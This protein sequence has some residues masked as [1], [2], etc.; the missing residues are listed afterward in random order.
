M[1]KFLFWLGVYADFSGR[2]YRYDGVALGQLQNYIQFPVVRKPLA[3]LL[4]ITHFLIDPGS[5]QIIRMDDTN[6]G[7]SAICRLTGQVCPA[8]FSH[9]YGKCYMKNPEKSCDLLTFNSGRNY[10]HAQVSDDSIKILTALRM[11]SNLLLQT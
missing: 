2:P 8:G 4:N 5:S 11:H 9:Y 10:T 1:F 6:K 7:F 3:A